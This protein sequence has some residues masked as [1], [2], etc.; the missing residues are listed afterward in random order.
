[1]AEERKKQREAEKKA[2]KE[3]LSRIIAGNN[4]VNSF[5]MAL[6][7][8]ISAGLLAI[9]FTIPQ[10]FLMVSV[11]SFIVSIY[12]MQLLPHETLK[13]VLRIILSPLFHIRIHNITNFYKAGKRV[14]LI[15]NHC[16]LLDGILVAA[17]MPEKITFAINTEWAKKSFF[18]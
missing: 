1:M 6:I 4:I 9:G 18:Q 10:L 3:R 15:A 7:S 16:S 11:V 8:I 12:I 13:S 5:G 17:Y 2:E 14:L